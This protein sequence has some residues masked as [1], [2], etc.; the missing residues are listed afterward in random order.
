MLY[1]WKQL[2][3]NLDI[4]LKEIIYVT[5]VQD[6]QRHGDFLF[7]TVAPLWN[8]EVAKALPGSSEHFLMGLD[9]ILS[10]YVSW[11]FS[12]VLEL[13]TQMWARPRCLYRPEATRFQGETDTQAVDLIPVWWALWWCRHRHVTSV[14]HKRF[15]RCALALSVLLVKQQN[16]ET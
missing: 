9:V 7:I 8:L 15:E 13:K 11:M 10:A 5:A 16:T 2:V 6:G 12:H 4:S 3:G 1:S 14:S